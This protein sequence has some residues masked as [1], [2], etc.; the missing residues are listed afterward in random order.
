MLN[1]QIKIRLL[2]LLHFKFKNMAS[3]LQRS[4]QTEQHDI[5]IDLCHLCHFLLSIRI[6]ELHAAMRDFY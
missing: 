2:S 4:G 5:Y 3:I 6:N 1:G